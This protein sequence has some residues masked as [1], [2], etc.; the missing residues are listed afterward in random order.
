MKIQIFP[1]GTKDISKELLD[2]SGHIKL[3]PAS[4]FN[5]FS[6]EEVRIF[7]HFYSRYCLVTQE[8][9]DTLK[10]FIGERKTIELGS[11]CGDLGYHLKIP[12][13]DNRLQEE[14]DVKIIYEAMMQPIIKYPDSVE[15]LEALDAIEKYKPEVAISTWTTTFGDPTKENYGCNERGL[16]EFE[17]IKKVKTYIFVGSEEIHGDKPII[18]KLYHNK[19]THPGLLSRT[20]NKSLNRIWIFNNGN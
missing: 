14:P 12:L 20:K 16:K 11:G 2:E 5:K 9:I 1:K 8:L 18:Q 19:I 15:K 7:C 6:W 4:Y 13:T 17:I 3:F 10:I